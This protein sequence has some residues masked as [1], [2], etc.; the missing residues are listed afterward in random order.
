MNHQFFTVVR[1]AWH[2]ISRSKLCSRKVLRTMQWRLDTF[3]DS[4]ELV[5]SVNV[6]IPYL[7]LHL[8]KNQTWSFLR[9]RKDR[10]VHQH[11]DPLVLPLWR[12]SWHT[13]QLSSCT[14][15]VC[16]DTLQLHLRWEGLWGSGRWGAGE[17]RLEYIGEIIEGGPGL[18]DDVQTD[19]AGHL[20]NV[21]MVDLVHEADAGRF[22]RIL[23]WQM[24]PHFP[25]TSLVRRPL[26]TEELY[27][28]LVQAIENCHFVFGLDQLDDV[29]VHSPL[30][31]TRRWHFD[32]W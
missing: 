29:C 23:F 13:Q 10:P 1:L 2:N 30:S 31:C 11:T 4:I 26:R 25:N 32:Y 17:E 15:Q 5:R 7:W 16:E 6:T 28:E 9:M 12:I 8:Q 24:D 20:V 22:E 27:Y 14:L 19:G 21:G 18:V 3:T